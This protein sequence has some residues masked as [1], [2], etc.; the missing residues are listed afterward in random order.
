MFAASGT[1]AVQKWVDQTDDIVREN[2]SQYKS[3]PSY[4]V[5]SDLGTAYARERT[6]LKTITLPQVERLERSTK[7]DESLKELIRT[8]NPSVLRD[9]VRYDEVL[10]EFNPTRLRE[11]ALT[12]ELD[13]TRS[14]SIQKLVERLQERTRTKTKT[15]TDTLLQQVLRTRLEEKTPKRP[16]LP[17]LTKTPL[18]LMSNEPKK[19]YDFYVRRSVP[20][21]KAP[22]QGVYVGRFPMNRGL[23]VAQ[24]IADNSSDRTVIYVPRGTTRQPDD[25][26]VDKAYKFRQ[27]KGK[28]KLRGS[29]YFVEKEQYSIDSEGELEGITAKGLLALRKKH[30]QIS[31]FKQPKQ[32]RF[33]YGY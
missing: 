9:Q 7:T 26:Y 4:G 20:K 25:L 22:V 14:A 28:S 3:L 15:K 32:R 29:N 1:V 27:P 17:R 30:S 13:I 21:G 2:K 33:K 18:G 12:Q 24:D 16:M 10:K 6:Y 11:E 23:N 19:S 8:N 5:T 31:F